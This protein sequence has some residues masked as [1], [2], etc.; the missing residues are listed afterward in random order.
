[1]FDFAIESRDR[2]SWARAGRLSTPHGIVETPAFM[3]VGTR[4]S[5]KALSVRDLEA[6]GARILLANTYHLYLRPGSGLVR[7]MGGL[8]RFM[9]WSGAL[10]TD[11]GGFQVLSLSDLRRVT[12]DG[13]VFRSHLDGSEHLLTP[14]R[15]IEI[16]TDLGADLIVAF[17]E[18]VPYPS[19]P[20]VV[21]DAVERTVRWARRSRDRF[22]ALAGDGERRQA[23]FG[24][25]QGSVHAD[26]RR[27]CVAALVEIGFD[28]Y[29][30][31]GL[32]VG[33][34]PEVLYEAIVPAVEGLP[35]GA[36]RYLMGVGYP[37]DILEAVTR[38]VDLFDCVLPTRNARNGTVF[39]SRGRLVIKNREYETDGR[40]LD[41]DCDCEA[42]QGYSRA[43]LR[44]LFQVN[45]MLGPRLAS[46]HSVRF[47]QR[48][49]AGI[50]ESLRADRFPAF[51][52]RFLERY[53]SGEGLASRRG[54]GGD[55]RRD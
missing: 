7:E 54:A 38:G 3:P 27:R 31:G 26:L 11:S 21:A 41:P 29:A 17:D 48:L 42:C 40:P 50:R 23:L 28:G 33:E 2:S 15:S 52:E 22:R 39:T 46:V 20:G 6:S 13:V 1:V 55:I 30:I 47:Y 18:L 35:P 19:P 5:V 14:E 45:E 9:G 10:L 12:E 24:I 44:H 25:S 8:H 4:G 43:Y 34:P 16:Q 36:P 51:R 53:E 49:M 32:A 37:R